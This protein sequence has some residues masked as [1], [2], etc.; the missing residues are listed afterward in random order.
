MLR[1]AWTCDRSFTYDGA[2][3]QVPHETVVWPKPRQKPYPPL[4]LAGTS[5]D[6][7]RL[8]AAQ[9][10]VPLTTG[11]LG[12]AGIRDTAALWVQERL[13]QGKPIDTLELGV[14][15][16]THVATSDTAARANLRYPRWQN[17]AGRALNRLAVVDG[18]VQPGPYEGEPDEDGL[19]RSIYYGSPA[20]ITAKL[21]RLAEA[22]ATFVSQWMMIGGMEHEKVMRSIRL[23]GE[24]V[25]PALR[26]IHPPNDL[27]EQLAAGWVAPET[28]KAR[29]QAPS[30]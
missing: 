14:Q 18:C 21:Q 5:P 11:F 23:M 20:T 24:E 4:W 17:R 6:S 27:Y 10:I 19:F 25:I 2:Y 8:A 15:A 30:D 26:D 7:I 9:D 13:A 22:G 28:L 1:L 3:I 29:G 12:P 16:I